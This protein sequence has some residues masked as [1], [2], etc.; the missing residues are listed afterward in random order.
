M[1]GLGGRGEDLGFYLGVVV[2]EPWR[3]AGRGGRELTRGLTG[4]L[5][6]PLRD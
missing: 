1:P 3:A 5:W 4:A 6:W 2:G